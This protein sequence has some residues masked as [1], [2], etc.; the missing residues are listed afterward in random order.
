MK[1][2]IVLVTGGRKY[3]DKWVVWTTLDCL[4]AQRRITHL[5]HGGAAG[6]DT[7]ADEW[8]E[9]RG[10]QPVACRA[11]WRTLGNGAGPRRN[12]RMSQLKPDCLVAF[13]GGGGT[14]S[15]L[16]IAAKA[17][18]EVREVMDRGALVRIEAPHFV[19]GICRQGIAPIVSYMRGW[20]VR[21]IREYCVNKDW[22]MEV[23]K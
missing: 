4:H 14:S 22:T 11:L 10:V 1:T 15:M 23:M 5:I 18:I 3:F 21:Q 12:H 6:A 17:G 20:T 9:S 13:P 19:A 7:L 16:E 8:A 2:F